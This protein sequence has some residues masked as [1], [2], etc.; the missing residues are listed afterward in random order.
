MYTMETRFAAA[1]VQ[2]HAYLQKENTQ[3][4]KANVKSKNCSPMAGLSYPRNISKNIL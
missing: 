2:E 4:A 3:K 1:Y